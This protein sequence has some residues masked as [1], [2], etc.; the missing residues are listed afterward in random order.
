MVVVL[1]G[2]AT[3]AF[4][5]AASAKVE[6]WRYP[7]L[8]AGLTPLRV[9]LAASSGA[10]VQASSKAIWTEPHYVALVFPATTRDPETEKVLGLA[11]DAV[12][13]LQQAGPLF[14]FEWR[15]LEGSAVIG[16]GSG[17]QK[18]LGAFGGPSL[19]LQFGVFPARAGH[20]YVV[21]AS[22]GPEFERLLLASPQLEV[23]VA[24]AL[25]SVGLA[26]GR[27]SDTAVV[28]FFAFVGLVFLGWAFV[29]NKGLSN[30]L[31]N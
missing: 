18:P 23:G 2:C 4:A 12:G 24:S 1:A 26:W 3:L 28:W 11:R 9:P 20:V 5:A 8:L 10:E 27:G 25:P 7:T 19:G 30:R 13:S 16:R 17:H 29:A 6:Q 22:L 31:T 15:V 21:V 14:D